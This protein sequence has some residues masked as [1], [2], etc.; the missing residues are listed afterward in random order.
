M[1]SR[2]LVRSDDLGYSKGV[3]YGIYEAVKNGFI[4]NVGFMVNMPTSQHG[5]DLVKDI[6]GLNL[7]LHTVICAGKPLTNPKLIPSITTEDGYFKAS[8][9]YRSAKEDFIDFDEVVTEI[10]AQYQKFVELV[11]RKPDYFEG[12]AVV[13]D[14]FVKG[15]RTVAKRH[16]VP[17]LDFAFDSEAHVS[18]KSVAFKSVMESMGNP[19]YNPVEVVKKAAEFAKTHANVIP[20]VIFHCGYL[21]DYILGHSSLTLPRTKEVE[22]SCDKDLAQWLKDNDVQLMRYSEV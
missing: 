11:G 19:N 2:I 12:H 18:F 21:D 20:M 15:L 13:S 6:E 14:N 8:K 17:F 16:D 7:G 9:T 1:T 10:E 22:A 4:N 5:L 3:N